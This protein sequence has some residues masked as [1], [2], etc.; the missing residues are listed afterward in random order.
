MWRRA[1]AW[2]ALGFG[3]GLY[4]VAATG[5]VSASVLGLG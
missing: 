4:L 5:P 1:L 3:L 2:W